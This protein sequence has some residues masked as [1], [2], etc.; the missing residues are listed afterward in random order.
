MSLPKDNRAALRAIPAVQELLQEPR[1]APFPISHPYLKKIIQQEIAVLR[2]RLGRQTISPEA[3]PEKLTQ[4]ILSRLTH[5]FTPRLQ[6]VINATGIILHT[7]LGRAPLAAAARQA[8][9]AVSEHY[10]NLEIRLETGKRSQRMDHLEDL[11]CLITGAEAALVV[12]NCAAAIFLT[13]TALC[14]RKEVPVSRGELVEIGGSF[15]MPEVMK[16]SGAKMVEIGTTNKTHLHDYE[17]AISPRTGALLKVHTSNYRVLGFT[18]SVEM[19]ELAGLAHRHGL[20]L[21][22][23]MGSGVLSDVLPETLS[24]EPLAA[25]MVRIGVDVIT[26]SGDK[27]PGGPQAGIIVGKKSYL[28]KIRKHHLARALRCDKLILAALEATLRLHLQPET[29]RETLPTVRLLSVPAKTL[30]AR[31][32]WL[33][34]QLQAGGLHVEIVES[35]AQ[36]GSGAMPLEKLPSI[37]LKITTKRF[38]AERL[39][40]NLRRHTPPVIGYVQDDALML[41]LRTVREDELAVVCEAL[42]SL[43]AR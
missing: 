17:A 43:Q 10:C 39:A 8:L 33:Q 6:R 1:F 24:G 16:A 11:L 14:K 30:R 26:F 5:L 20:P 27:L 32:E 37:A 12:N 41:N 40:K 21:I 4:Q 9:A 18:R 7:N 2:E 36:I 15:R 35:F 13:L 23:D 29:L 25:E 31:A 22:F 28:Q 38:S 34:N 19:P 42:Q 3:V